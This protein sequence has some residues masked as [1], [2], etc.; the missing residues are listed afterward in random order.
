LRVVMPAFGTN[1]VAIRRIDLA[2]RTDIGGLGNCSPSTAFA[3]L[4]GVLQEG[5][6]R[7]GLTA[8]EGTGIITPGTISQRTASPAGSGLA[9]KVLPR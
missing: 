4:S 6:S 5:I 8:A 2:P 7:I 3:M 9:R 1:M